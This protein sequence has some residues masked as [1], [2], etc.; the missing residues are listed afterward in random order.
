MNIDLGD[1]P[2]ILLAPA[3]RRF[4]RVDRVGQVYKAVHRKMQRVVTVKILPRSQSPVW[5]QDE[6][7]AA[8]RLSHPNTVMAFDADESNGVPFLVMEFTEGTDLHRHV[9]EHGPLSVEKAVNFILQA[10]QGL[11]VSGTKVT[12]AGLKRLEKK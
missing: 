2:L 5:V 12:A 1:T 6:V 11:G 4:G 3:W 9:Q 8:A 7:T 10:A